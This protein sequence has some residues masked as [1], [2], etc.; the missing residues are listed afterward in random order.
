M[1][2][3]LGVVILNEGLKHDESEWFEVVVFLLLIGKFYEIRIQI[4]LI[5]L[6][7]WR[8]DYS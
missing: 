1:V 2:I 4:T 7:S 6:V 8:F 3:G 5:N